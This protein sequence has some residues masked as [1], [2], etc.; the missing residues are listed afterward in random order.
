[1]ASV[2]SQGERMKRLRLRRPSAALV[3]S[4][5]ALFVA[6]GG[7]VYAGTSISG[8]T[9]KKSSLPGNRVKKNSLPG[10]RV[11]KNSLTGVQINE[12]KLGQVPSAAS[13]GSAGSATNAANVDTV[14]PFSVGADAET[15][16]SLVKTANFELM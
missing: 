10:N 6:L 13:A 15:M 16:V 1:D 3:I 12:S 9:I 4:C 14:K 7:T 5:L 8:K 11:K 2:P